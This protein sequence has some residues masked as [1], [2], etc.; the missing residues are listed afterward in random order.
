MEQR[1]NDAL[2]RPQF[3]R[4]AVSC[5]AGFALLLAV[6]GVY[7]VVSYTVARRAHEMGV[8]MALGTTPAGLRVRLLRDGLLTIGA[9]V[10]PGVVG[11]VLSGKFLESLVEGAKP[12]DAATYVATILSIAL[13][14]AVGIWS[15]TRPI[16][17]LDIVEVLRTE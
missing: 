3:Y 15:A 12:A 6:I 2:A 10:V 5:F 13:I 9:G 8:R 4:T 16:V 1:L 14:A 7:G 11:A 17:R